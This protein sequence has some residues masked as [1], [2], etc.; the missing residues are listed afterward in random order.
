V[1]SQS[2]GDRLYRADPKAG[3]CTCPDHQE[4]G[5]KCKHVYAVDKQQ[6]AQHGRERDADE[7]AGRNVLVLDRAERVGAA[8]RTHRPV[9]P[10]ASDA[11]HR[12]GRPAVYFKSSR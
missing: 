1:P 2:G 10:P 7:A 12:A 4:A 8:R 3:T 5:F 11:A 6:A 9:H